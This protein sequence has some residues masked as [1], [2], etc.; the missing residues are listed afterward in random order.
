MKIAVTAETPTGLESPVGHHFGRSPYY[1]LV[2]VEEGA[3]VAAEAVPNPSA[4]GHRPGELPA[5]IKEMGVE[6]LISG[7]M[8][9]RAVAFF[10]EYGIEVATGA[11]GTVR[12][13]VEAYLAG[14]LRG[15]APCKDHERGHGHHHH[16]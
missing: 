14:R 15:A 6:V 13:A 9:P 8:G 11:Q 16:H 1:V 10:R 4:N 2:T 3:V 7:G 5:L 12:S